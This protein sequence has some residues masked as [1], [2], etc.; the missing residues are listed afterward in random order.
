MTEEIAKMEA[1]IE[2][3]ALV[4]E[5]MF[6]YHVYRYAHRY[7]QVFSPGCRKTASR[8]PKYSQT[9]SAALRVVDKDGAWDIKKRFGPHPDDP[10]GS[11]GRA[12]YQ[13]KVLLSDY[14]PCENELINKRVGRSPWCW[15]LPEAIS[16]AALLAKLEGGKSAV[17]EG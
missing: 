11:A 13:A 14:D 12:T 17:R 10:P 4:A 2:L 3:D 1:G 5:V 6:D 15:S 9:G 7:W 8:M 16:K